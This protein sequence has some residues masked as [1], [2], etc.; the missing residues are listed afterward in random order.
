MKKLSEQLIA[1]ASEGNFEKVKEL[2]K[3]GA[4]VNAVDEDGYTALMYTAG[5]GNLDIVKY[6]IEDHGA[7]VNA[8]AEYGDT[9]LLNAE[10]E[11]HSDIAEYLK[12]KME[13]S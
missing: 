1:A 11:G 9:A 13:K 4:D 7:D 5:H 10:E 12:Q 6:L 2:V 3:Q 8:E